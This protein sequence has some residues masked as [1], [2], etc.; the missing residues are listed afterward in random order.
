MD[1]V[2]MSSVH[3]NRQRMIAP[4]YR[5]PG[6]YE[7]A[8]YQSSDD[9]TVWLVSAICGSLVLGA[10]LGKRAFDRWA[11]WEG[12]ER[13][14]PEKDKDNE[15]FHFV[16]SHSTSDIGYGSCEWRS[17]ITKFDV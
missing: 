3:T 6:V 16:H 13:H 7:S 9:Q 2:F 12:A 8:G 15:E 1:Y 17:D 5:D 11:E 4:R 14:V 10:V